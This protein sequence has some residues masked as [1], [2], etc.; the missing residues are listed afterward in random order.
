MSAEEIQDTDRR[1]LLYLDPPYYVKG[2]DLYQHGFTVDDHQRLANALRHTE[3][4]WVLSYDDCCEVRQLYN[5]ANVESLQV[6]YSITAT[7]DK[8]TG[9]RVSRTKGELL[10]CPKHAALAALSGDLSASAIEVAIA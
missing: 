9:E 3:H 7:K 5:W 2:N 10:I 4:A 8:D 6:N 1:S